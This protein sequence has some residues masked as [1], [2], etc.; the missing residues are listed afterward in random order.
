MFAL[1]DLEMKIPFQ[2]ANLLLENFLIHGYSFHDAHPLQSFYFALLGSNS[3]ISIKNHS[4]SCSTY[5]ENY[6]Q[7][8]SRKI[9]LNKC[10]E[11]HSS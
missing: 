4:I 2:Q 7:I 1:V 10:T 3:C 6:S 9:I 8:P 11:Q 5:D